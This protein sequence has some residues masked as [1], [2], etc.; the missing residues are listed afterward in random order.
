M[1]AN[2][3]LNTLE[4]VQN[5]RVRNSPITA[6][7]DST[8]V[9]PFVQVAELRFIRPVLCA[10]LYN[11]MIAKKNTI[12][13]AYTKSGSVLSTTT[14]KFPTMPAYEALW[15]QF[16]YSLCADAVYYCSVPNMVIS[17]GS[18]GLY[19]NDTEGGKNAGEKNAKLIMDNVL[20]GIESLQGAMI[21]YI[22]ANKTDFP[23]FPAS[24]KCPCSD[25]CGDCRGN[26]GTVKKGGMYFG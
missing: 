14:A 10:D 17:T 18:S 21:E 26:S 22:C 20:K 4:M 2:T 3:I 8:K 13:C 12:D 9:D 15:V 1:T 19:L 11:D 24:E 5:G 7:F 25:E 16:L 6:A 23:L